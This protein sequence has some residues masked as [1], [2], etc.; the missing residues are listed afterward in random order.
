MRLFNINTIYHSKVLNFWNDFWFKENDGIPLAIF[1]IIMFSTTLFILIIRRQS[2]YL[3]RSCQFWESYGIYT[4]LQV[5]CSQLFLN[6]LYWVALFFSFLALLGIAYRLTGKIGSF[7]T[8]LILGYN[9]N[10]KAIYH[11]FQMFVM[12]LL[13]IGFSLAADH[14][15]IDSF[16]SKKKK[17]KSMHYCWPLKISQLYVVYVYLIVGL[18]K[19]YYSGFKWVF[20]E[21]LFLTVFRSPQKGYLSDW[22]ISQP[23]WFT[24]LIAFWSLFICELL[25]PLALFHKKL[26][27]LFFIIWL[28]FHT[29]V[30][31]ILGGHNWFY[32]QLAAAS[33]F[34]LPLLTPTSETSETTG[35]S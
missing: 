23:Y 7:S 33:V 24:V 20:S 14:L 18:E 4:I 29:G 27:Y 22:F 8:M 13:F 11:N 3:E 26:G 2:F 19:L 34:L 21:N 10:F 15:S 32:T 12:V 31:L 17:L 25:S 30:Y 16:F 5:P 1:R 6:S 9:Y 35:I 28:S